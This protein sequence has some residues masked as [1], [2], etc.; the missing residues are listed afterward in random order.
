MQGL[1]S[2]ITGATLPAL[3][4]RIDGT[5]EEMARALVLKSIGF[6][7]GSLIGGI[8]VERH[9]R[10]TDLCLL[11]SLISGAAAV[12]AAPWCTSLVLLCVDF[13]VDGL[14]KGIIVAGD[15]DISDV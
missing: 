3:K 11:L 1:F 6:F 9:R 2:E 12:G 10:L 14:A 13:F 8:F 7:F 15:V 4:Y 5:Y